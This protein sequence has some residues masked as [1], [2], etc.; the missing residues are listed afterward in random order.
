[1]HEQPPRSPLGT[2]LFAL[3][4]AAPWLLA[5]LASA[6]NPGMADE[7]CRKEGPLEHLTHGVLLAALVAH[8]IRLALPATARLRHLFPTLLCLV[9]LLEE[10]DY[11]QVYLGFETPSALRALTGRSD[12]LNFHNTR[13][14]DVLIPVFYSLYLIAL[15]LLAFWPG[16]RAVGRRVRVEPL[17]P[18]V[19]PLF[20]SAVLASYLLERVGYIGFDPTEMLDLSAAIALLAPALHPRLLFRGSGLP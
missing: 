14:A 7:L 8:A 6:T 3:A 15:P 17:A 12:H 16:W 20:F 13:T 11:G 2:A 10:I 18:M 4:M 5:A 9:F 19:A 1:M